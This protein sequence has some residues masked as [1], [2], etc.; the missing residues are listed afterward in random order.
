MNNIITNKIEHFNIYDKSRVFELTCTNSNTFYI[1][2]AIESLIQDLKN[3]EKILS[4]Q[5]AN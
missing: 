2:R 3:I 1:G 4:T 5:K